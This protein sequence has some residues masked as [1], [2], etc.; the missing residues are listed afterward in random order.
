MAV[1]H[2][3]CLELCELAG[4]QDRLLAVYQNRRCAAAAAA[5]GTFET[6]HTLHR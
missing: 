2:A 5:A 6:E 4:R 1:S 3:E